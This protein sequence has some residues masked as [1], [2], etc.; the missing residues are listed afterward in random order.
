MREAP[1]AP[2]QQPTQLR[3]ELLHTPRQ[4]RLT[5][6]AALGGTSKIEGVAKGEEVPDLI[7]FH[8]ARAL[9]YAR[10]ARPDR[11]QQKTCIY[12]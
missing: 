3:L 4:R 2:N 9:S 11:V 6:A 7:E 5:D 8:A 12:S 10:S 1:L